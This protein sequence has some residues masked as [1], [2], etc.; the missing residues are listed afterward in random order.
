MNKKHKIFLKNQLA[1]K[2]EKFKDTLI[3]HYAHIE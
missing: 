2:T 1:R 3:T